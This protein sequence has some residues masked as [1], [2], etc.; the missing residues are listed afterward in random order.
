M[1]V[2]KVPISTILR[3]ELQTGVDEDGNPVFRNKSFGNDKPGA[4]D[5]DLYDVAVSL[6]ALQE[7]PLN[8]V[9]RIDNAHLT[10]E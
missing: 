3:L 1:A 6:A 7:F 8:N 5:Q 4:S 10:E 2:S 9:L